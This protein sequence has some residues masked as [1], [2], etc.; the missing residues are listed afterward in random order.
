MRKVLNSRSW[1]IEI[2]SYN[3]LFNLNWQPLST[4]IKF[5][6]LKLTPFKQI[7][8]HF[9]GQKELSSKLNLLINLQTFCEE[10]RKFLFDI[11]PITYFLDL[12]HLEKFD[13]EFQD[14]LNCFL[15]K[16]SLFRSTSL[17]LGSYKLMKRN[18]YKK[19]CLYSQP[20]NY[21]TLNCGNNVW[22]LKPADYN[23]GRGI[24]LFN[25]LED[26][27]LILLEYERFELENYNVLNNNDKTSNNKPLLKFVGRT[28]NLTQKILRKGSENK[29]ELK[30]NI[31]KILNSSKLKTRRFIIQ[32]YIENPFLINERKFDMRVWVLL[33]HE[34]NVFF[35]R[36]GY[37]RT[38]SEIYN[39]NENELE[40]P[41]IHLTNNAIQKNSEK[42][43]TFEKGNQLS[44]HQLDVK[45]FEFIKVFFKDFQRYLREINSK[46]R[47]RKHLV[48]NMK[49]II[50]LCFRAAQMKLNS[51]NRQ[52]CFE[53][54]GFDFMIDASFSLWL[55]EINTNPCL[56]E[57]SPLLKQLIPRMLGLNFY[58]I[59][60]KMIKN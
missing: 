25:T 16:S 51:N 8:N 36:E 22:I 41:Y 10:N 9:E 26:L 45:L 50:L 21:A 35:F 17:N 58:L 53:I 39:L 54:F 1:W 6:R 42:Y 18:F 34:M 49:E 7:V 47:V 5:D 46:I 44:F 3:T 29:E 13:V 52:F 40:N 30:R 20:R 4:N 57:S 2:P 28:V 24:R 32:K 59:K 43:G 31:L 11:I 37:I 33:N 15:G 38:S 55:L 19:G 12:D 23:R 56:E 14:F 48:P 60:K 27:Q